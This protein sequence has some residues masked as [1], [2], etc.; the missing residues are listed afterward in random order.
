LQGGHSCIHFTDVLWP[1]FSFWDFA[2]CVVHYQ[3]EHDTLLALRARADAKACAALTASDAA[4][5]ESNDTSAVASHAAEREARISQFINN[6]HR[7]RTEYFQ[8]LA[9]MP[10]TTSID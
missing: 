8:R 10:P 9:E 1:D 3:G 6:V 2:K 7:G 5:C 4:A